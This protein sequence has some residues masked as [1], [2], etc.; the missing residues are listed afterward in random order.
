M[1]LR[2]VRLCGPENSSRAVQGKQPLALG[3]TFSDGVPPRIS[4]L[5]TKLISGGCH[6]AVQIGRAHHTPSG[7]GGGISQH[8]EL[9]DKLAGVGVVLVLLTTPVPAL[10]VVV[11][12]V[13]V[14]AVSTGVIAVSSTIPAGQ[15]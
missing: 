5:F 11:G 14:T 9:T 8:W 12:F 10:A 15:P 3:D 6:A 13:G 1:T 4:K 2:S 7:S